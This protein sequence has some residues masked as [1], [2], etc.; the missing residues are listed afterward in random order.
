MLAVL[1]AIDLAWVALAARARTLL[2]S[3]RAMRLT[4]RLSAGLMTGA[5]AGI[6]SR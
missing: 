5:A 6:A 4:N 2:R 3:P 1:V